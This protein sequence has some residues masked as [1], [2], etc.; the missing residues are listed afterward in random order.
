VRQ[1]GIIQAGDEVHPLP[2]R[3]TER[4]TIAEFLK[5]YREKRARRDQI[6]RLLSLAALPEDWKNRLRG[7]TEARS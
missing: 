2:S 7:K 3:E 6:R 5:L 4:V 1:E